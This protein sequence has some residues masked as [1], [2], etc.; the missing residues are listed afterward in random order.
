MTE[1]LSFCQKGKVHMIFLDLEGSKIQDPKI[2]HILYQ[3]CVE[4]THQLMEEHNAMMALHTKLS[5]VQQQH[6][7]TV[8]I[9]LIIL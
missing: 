3:R 6:F 9:K 7:C 5:I 4:R 8:K 2:H 1:I